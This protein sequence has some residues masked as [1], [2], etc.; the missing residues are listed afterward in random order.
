[1][2]AT[3]QP[4]CICG[5]DAFETTFDYLEPPPGEVRFAFSEG[6]G[7]RRKVLC[8]TRCGHFL[9]VHEMDT[10]KLYEGAYV[11]AT[12]GADG[13]RRAF[14]RIVALDPARS[15]NVGRVTRIVA[16]AGSHFGVQRAAG[17]LTILDVGS[18]LCVFLHRIRTTTPW[19]ATALDPDERAVRH[20]RECAGVNA[21]RADFMQCKP[22]SRFDIV[23]LNKVLEHVIDP[24]AM[25]RHAHDFL[26][27]GGFVYVELPDG[28]DAQSEGPGREEFFIDHLHVF[29][30]ESI[31]ILANRAGFHCDH[32]ERLREPSSKFTLRAFLSAPAP[33]QG[34][35]T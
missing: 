16:Y 14:D 26:A 6:S 12:Y 19:I 4:V 24:V 3:G 10:S 15:D 5:N 22:A 8:C 30:L 20:A 18:G 28:E 13:L 35:Q 1:M 9:S 33:T 29:S 27:P 31:R 7:Y 17:P 25:L 32:V 2:S 23:T 34:A 11:D 21:I